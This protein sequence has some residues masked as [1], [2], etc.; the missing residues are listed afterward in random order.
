MRGRTCGRCPDCHNKL[1]FV[2]RAEAKRWNKIHHWECRPYPCPTGSGYF[3]LGHLADAI[4]NGSFELG[5]DVYRER[6][7]VS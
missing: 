7:K 5:R 4:R 6:G 3:H 2:S 1:N